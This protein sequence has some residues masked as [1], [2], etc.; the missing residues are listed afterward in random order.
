[1]DT[2]DPAL[3]EYFRA[4][5]KFP[6]M[7]P[8]Q[9]TE[10]AHEIE[11]CEV[12]RWAALLAHGPSAG[13]ILTT[14]HEHLGKLESEADPSDRDPL[15]RARMQSESLLKTIGKAG[16]VKAEAYPKGVRALAAM[17][18]LQDAD[19]LWVSRAREIVAESLGGDRACSAFRGV[20]SAFRAHAIAKNRFVQA[21]LRL[22]VSVARGYRRG[23]MPLLDMIQEGNIGLMKGV[24]QFDASRG[25][26]F[27][28]YGAWWIR[29]TITRSLADKGRVVRLPVHILEAR[30]HVY[31]ATQVFLAQNGRE[32]TLEELETKTGLSLARLKTLDLHRNSGT[33]SLDV[34]TG[35]FDDGGSGDTFLS[36]LRDEAPSPFDRKLEQDMA[37]ESRRLLGTLSPYDARILRGRFGIDDEE[38]TLQE[39]GDK[40]GVTRERVRQRQETSLAKLRLRLLE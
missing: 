12:D 24:D 39:L 38:H 16:K 30:V 34:K 35:D 9:E 19:R 29:H 27:S 10:A 37:R 14:L 32:P 7:S 15:S 28:T 23:V 40:L 5:S 11:R 20:E 25:Y 2:I 22:V 36:S 6:V 18:R 33:L 8:E 13:L 21:N 26:R 3:A 17:I 1:V 31:R 4:M